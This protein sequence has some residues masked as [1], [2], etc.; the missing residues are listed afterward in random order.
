MSRGTFAG[1]RRGFV[2]GA[3]AA[4]AA[5]PL[6]GREAEASPAEIGEW[7]PVYAWPCVAIHMIQLD[8]RILTFA[9][10]DAVFPAR[11]ADFS[12]TFV[13]NI[14]INGL[15]QDPP[16]YLPNNATNLFCAGHSHIPGP[17]SRVLL[18][19]GHEGKQYYGSSD[20]TT[21]D[22]TDGYVMKTQTAY[23]MNAGRWY[24]T[25]SVMANGEIVVISGSIKDSQRNVNPLPQVWRTGIGGWRNLTDA[26]RKILYYPTQVVVPNGLLYLTGRAQQTLYLDTAGRGKW[27]N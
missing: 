19:G 9:D 25:S 18:L 10:D 1:D 17:R 23:P 8:T 2:F 5:V 14:P 3:A 13:V 20:V 16:V 26:V 6:F 12:K 24:A 11:N 4:A 7:S 21:F 15:P 27:Y 22:Y